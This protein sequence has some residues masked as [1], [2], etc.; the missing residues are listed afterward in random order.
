[1]E[2]VKR[3]LTWRADRVFFFDEAGGSASIHRRTL[4]P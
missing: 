3:L 2:F 1:L 4:A